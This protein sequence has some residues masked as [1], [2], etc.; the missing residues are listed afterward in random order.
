MAAEALSDQRGACSRRF[1]PRKS[2]AKSAPG[3]GAVLE[4]IENLAITSLAGDSIGIP[5]AQWMVHLQFRRFAGCPVCDLHLSSFKR[6]HREIEQAGVREVVIFHSDAADLLTYAND[7]PFA[8]VADSEKRLYRQFGVRTSPRALLD[9]R[10]WPYIALGIVRSLLKI[11]GAGG[12]IPP[13]SP[14]GGSFGLPADILIATDGRVLAQKYGQ[15][16]YD[17]WSVD[18]L[19]E[20]ARSSSE[21]ALSIGNGRG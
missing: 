9:P 8:L 18:E 7:L 4:S 15:H 17:Q 11:L 2:R 13:I 10:V 20:L 3:D 12:A 16:A 14:R 21:R 6:R 19:L 1:M 5:D